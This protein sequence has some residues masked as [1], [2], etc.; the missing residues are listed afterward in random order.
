MRKT[1]KVVVL[2]LLLIMMVFTVLV[3]DLSPSVEVSSS[4]QVNNADTVQPLVD[5]LRKSLRSRYESQ[6]I[7]VSAAQANSLAGFIHR[8]LGQANAQFVFSEEQV[9][10]AVTYEIRTGLFPLYFNL[11]AVVLESNT[12]QMGSVSLGDLP[13]PGKFALSIAESLANAYTSSEVAT[14]AIASVKSVAVESDGMLVT[15]AP[16][17]SLL[18]E[19]KNIETGGSR[20]DT[21]ILKIRIAHYLRLLDGMYIPPG[22]SN[23][24]N[25]SLSIYLHAVMQEA[26][27]LSKDGSATLENEA[28]ILAVAIYA[29]SRRFTTLTGDLSFAIDRIPFASPKPMLSGRQDLSLH[30]IFSAAIKLLSEKG[31]SIAVGEFKELMDRGKG[32]SGYSFVD[33]AADLSGTHFADLAVDPKRAQTVQ[34]VMLGAANENLFLVSTVGFDEGLSK[35]EFTEKYGGVDNPRYQKVVDEINLRI[36]NLPISQ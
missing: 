28:A 14:K 2:T 17:D 32:G 35:T 29:G 16:L 30:F 22:P 1:I 31:V 33:L 3:F 27:V 34:E 12:L 11:E 5:D 21:R 23:T 19:F 9:I 15:L 8:A 25:P 26:A 7:N 18:R 20:K 10:I 36:N 24:K 6:Q 13:L 4:E